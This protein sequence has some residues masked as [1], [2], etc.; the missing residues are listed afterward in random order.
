MYCIQSISMSIIM[1]RLPMANS[2]S[3]M[4]ISILNNIGNVIYQM[5]IHVRISVRSS[6]KC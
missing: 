5:S 4:N 1:C 6:V 2:I 3:G